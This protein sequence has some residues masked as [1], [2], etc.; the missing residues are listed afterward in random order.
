MESLPCGSLKFLRFL[1][2]WRSLAVGFCFWMIALRNSE[3]AAAEVT[4]RQVPVVTGVAV[5]VGV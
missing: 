3:Q 4:E 5:F 1:C 2:A